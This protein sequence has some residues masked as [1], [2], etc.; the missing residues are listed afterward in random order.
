MLSPST[1]H[2]DQR[3]KSLNYE[4]SLSIEEYLILAQ[5]ECCALVHRRGQHW[6]AQRLDG[7]DAELELHSLGLSLRL[8][9]IYDGVRF[10]PPSVSAGE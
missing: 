10:A 9:E 8:G 2:I 3:E 4:R 5:S 6:R 7:A 1:R